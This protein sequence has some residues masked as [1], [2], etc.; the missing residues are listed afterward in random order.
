MSDGRGVRRLLAV[1]A[2]VALAA[3][4]CAFHRSVVNAGI[5]D[6]DPSGIHAGRSTLLDVVQ[7]IGLPPPE[8]PEEA[9][10]RI[11]TRDYL[12]YA[13]LE[14]R[15]F[16]FGFEGP[17]L[18]TPFRWCADARVYELGVELDARGVVTGVFEATRGVPWRPFQ[19]ESAKPASARK[20]SG[21]LR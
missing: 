8:R 10:T 3:P 6:L 1:C 7:Q 13:V 18:V 19:G 2:L 12:R 5:R 11:A 15:C 4:G 21:S 16:V 9:G 20:L 14:R 17:L